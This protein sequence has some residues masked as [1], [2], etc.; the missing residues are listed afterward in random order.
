MCT[1]F[2]QLVVWGTINRLKSNCMCWGRGNWHLK[3]ILGCTPTITYFDSLKE[4]YHKS[5]LVNRLLGFG[6]ILRFYSA[7]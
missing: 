3:K 4:V 7:Q 6:L 2:V 5:K 1:G